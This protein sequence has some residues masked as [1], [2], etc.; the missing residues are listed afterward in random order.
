[1]PEL[2]FLPAHNGID[3][4]GQSGGL[5]GETVYAFSKGF[6]VFAREINW[7]YGINHRV[8]PSE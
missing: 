5:G 8:G 2:P 1:V 3:I 4:A 7:D 6:V